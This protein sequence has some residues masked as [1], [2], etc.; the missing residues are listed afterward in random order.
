MCRNDDFFIPKWITYY[1]EQFGYENMFLF[2]DGF[3]QVAPPESKSINVIKVPRKTLNRTQ[4]DRNRARLISTFAKTLFHRYDI[5]IAHDI[6]EFLVLDP[7]VGIS[8]SQ[9]LQQPFSYSSLSGLGL[10]VGQHLTLELPLDPTRPFL[11][12]RMYA[13]VSSR[14]TKPVVAT[15]PVVWGSGFHRVKGKNFHI[16]PNLFLFHT[17]MIDE[18]RAFGKKEDDTRKAEGWDAHHSRR[19]QLFDLIQHTEA[20]D[21]DLIFDRARKRQ[22]L[23]RP[24]YALNKPGRLKEKPIIKIPERF[25]GVF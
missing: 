10:D 12:Q 3:D 23:F 2:L 4:G 18:E 8:L 20:V 19:R 5:V 16:D 1:G 22:N 24:I 21:G 13:H 25:K 14:Y 15:K 17:G 11:D 7:I 6:D 9:Y